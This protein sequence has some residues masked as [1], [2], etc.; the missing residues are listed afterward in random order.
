MFG[1]RANGAAKRLHILMQPLML[2][3]TK[4][5]LK[6]K[7][8]LMTLPEKSVEDVLFKLETEEMNVYQMIMAYSR[9]LFE[10]FLTQRAERDNDVEYYH[11]YD[12][13]QHNEIYDR[14]L[15]MQDTSEVKQHHILTLILRLR[16]ICCHPALILSVS[17]LRIFFVFW[18]E[19]RMV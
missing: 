10:Q 17:N 19:S 3:R 11:H 13:S 15:N 14:L 4:E 5:Q 6:A 7:G 9:S 18:T 16:Q 2:R 12:T 1:N 8:V